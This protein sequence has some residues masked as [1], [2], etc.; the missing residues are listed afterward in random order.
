MIL[1]SKCTFA[2]RAFQMLINGV[3][4]TAGFDKGRNERERVKDGNRERENTIQ[5]ENGCFRSCIQKRARKSLS[6]CG[7][8]AC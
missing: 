6:Y 3:R 1:V 2:Q 5:T 4:K 8:I 7:K